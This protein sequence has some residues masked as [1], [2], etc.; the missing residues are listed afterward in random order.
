[1]P[2]RERTKAS[3]ACLACRRSKRRCNG[4]T[5]ACSNCV[6]SGKICHYKPE[7]DGRKHVSGAY[8]ESLEQQLRDLTDVLEGV[9]HHHRTEAESGAL[10]HGISPHTST[11]KARE[12]PSD[13]GTASGLENDWKDEETLALEESH[14]QP[15]QEQSQ[16]SVQPTGLAAEHDLPS[17]S[18]GFASLIEQVPLA[19]ITDPRSCPWAWLKAC[20]GSL[21]TD[22]PPNQ[23]SS[24]IEMSSELEEPSSE[25]GW[26]AA[27]GS[28]DASIL[29]HE[30]DLLHLFE[31]NF[32]SLFGKLRLCQNDSIH[33]HRLSANDFLANATCSLGA[34]CATSAAV[35]NVGQ[36]FQERAE[37]A[38]LSLCRQSDDFRVYQGT[39]ILEYLELSAGDWKMSQIYHEISCTLRRN[40]EEKETDA[41]LEGVYPE[42][43]ETDEKET[44]KKA[45]HTHD[46]LGYILSAMTGIHVQELRHP[47]TQGARH[48]A[49]FDSDVACKASSIEKGVGK[50]VLKEM[51]RIDKMS[52]SPSI[53]LDKMLLETHAKLVK[54][55]K[56]LPKTASSRE[57]AKMTSLVR[58]RMA[59]HTGYITLHS[60]LLSLSTSQRAK[61]L[62]FRLSTD[63]AFQLA[64]LWLRYKQLFDQTSVPIQVVHYI[65]C[66]AVILLMNASSS[67]PDVKIKAKPLFKAVYDTLTTLSEAIPLA[68]LAANVLHHIMDDWGLSH[69]ITRPSRQQSVILETELPSRPRIADQSAFVETIDKGREVLVP[70]NVGFMEEGTQLDQGN[71]NSD[72]Q[73]LA[74]QFL[75][76]GSLHQ[77]IHNLD[78]QIFNQFQDHNNNNNLM[79]MDPLDL[80]HP[81]P[82][83]NDQ[84]FH[85]DLSSSQPPSH[86]AP[87]PQVATAAP[88]AHQDPFSF[89][90]LLPHRDANSSIPNHS[91]PSQEAQTTSSSSIPLPTYSNTT[92][93]LTHYPSS[94]QQ[95]HNDALNLSQLWPMHQDQRRSPANPFWG[96]P[97]MPLALG[98]LP[99]FE[100]YM[101]EGFGPNDTEPEF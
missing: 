10:S 85:F 30:A 95:G 60:H 86:F 44:L 96:D 74:Q 90:D 42:T 11:L 63:R 4:A 78:D 56:D 80:Q 2:Q 99:E 65:Y 48:G 100:T 58:A 83:I 34:Q 46:L 97:S 98:S 19:V 36:M 87:N 61:A 29:N 38:V 13:V 16:V 70:S 47:H 45:S 71:D 6:R 81:Y 57:L 68:Q 89:A 23:S 28:V 40:L 73:Q 24:S 22:E 93:P 3:N 49:H 33:S 82:S 84:S 5:P 27:S 51:R 72:I 88:Q 53:E 76:P 41:R 17:S 1:M 50:L 15:A 12:G 35:R 8:V 52:G 75:P 26:S 69:I 59:I 54:L 7:S 14:S 66:A 67:N 64:R 20:S 21:K 101:V 31:K 37:G 62:A 43:S 32:G 77:D 92:V 91:I 55:D 39:V 25:F 79:Q 9:R 94:F 18:H